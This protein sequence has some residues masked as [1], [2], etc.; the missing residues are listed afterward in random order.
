MDCSEAAVRSHPF[1]KI[2]PGNTGGRVTLLVKLQSD[3]SEWR[4][5]T[6][7]TPPRM[8]SWKSS[9]WTVEKQPSTVINF[10][11]F[12]QKI[13]VL[14]SFFWSN[15]ILTVESSDYILKRLNQVQKQPRN[16]KPLKKWLT[17]SGNSWADLLSPHHLKTSAFF[18]FR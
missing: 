12:L 7:M 1:L 18:I 15:Y 17:A 10:Q 13:P 2:S 9:A 11:T 5:Y 4:L 6:K 14:K 3:C 16:L 8:F